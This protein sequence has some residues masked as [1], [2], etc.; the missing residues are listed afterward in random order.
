MLDNGKDWVYTP[1][2]VRRIFMY[3]GFT[4]LT[5]IALFLVIMRV[6]LNEWTLAFLASYTT[7]V[8]SMLGIYFYGRQRMD[9]EVSNPAVEIVIKQLASKVPQL[10]SI[11][12]QEDTTTPDE[13]RPDGGVA[14]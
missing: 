4:T 9:R 6:N 10:K 13:S 11:L 12:G 8:G 1:P 3:I 14:P 7:V 5:F 2:I